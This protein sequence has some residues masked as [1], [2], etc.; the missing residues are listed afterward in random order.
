M[1]VLCVCVRVCVC[2]CLGL[3]LELLLV[4]LVVSSVECAEVPLRQVSNKNSV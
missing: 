3:G 2:V 4:F 1:C